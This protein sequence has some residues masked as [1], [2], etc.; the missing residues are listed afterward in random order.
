MKS[1][2]KSHIRNRDPQ[3]LLQP[4]S[5][6]SSGGKKNRRIN[7]S[8]KKVLNP[9][10]ATGIKLEEDEDCTRDGNDDVRQQQGCCLN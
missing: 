2:I 4:V 7:S 5:T 1:P 8:L 3:S 6:R 10:S 9:A